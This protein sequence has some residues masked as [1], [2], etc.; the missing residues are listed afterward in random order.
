MKLRTILAGI[1]V[2]GSFPIAATAASREA[3]K[4]EPV[5]LACEYRENPLGIDVQK[6][7]LFWWLADRK[8]ETGSGHREISSY[9][10][11]IP[12]GVQQTA[13]Q[14]LVA[15]SE[16]L[17][18]KDQGDL[19]ESGR[20]ESNQSIQVEYSGKPLGSFQYCYWKVRVWTKTNSEPGTLNSVCGPWS[21]PAFWVT[22]L[23]KPDDWQ[24]K[25]I[26]FPANETS[27][28]MRKEFSIDAAPGRA[29][30]F[31]NVK[32]YYEL[33]VNGKKVDDDVLSPAVSDFSKRTFY[34]AH[35]ISRF[36][37]PGK[38]C[39]G[40]W[41]GTG[42]ARSGM[43]ARV[44][45]N[46]TIGGRDEV[47]GTDK[48]WT[49]SPSSYTLLGGWKWAD[50]GV[51]SLD[52][53]RDIP[54]WS[55]A[56]C[57]TGKWMPV[58]ECRAPAGVVVA[59]TCEPNRIGRTIPLVKCTALGKNIWELDFGVN[60]TGWLKI[61]MPK[62][63]QGTRISWL[64]A[65]RRYQSIEGD[66][67]PAGNIRATRAFRVKADGGDIAYQYFNQKDEFISAGKE[68]EQFCSKFSYHG[69]RY[70][71]LY[72]FPVQ[73]TQDD[74]EALPIA[75]DLGAAGSFECSNDLLNRI[76]Q[77]NLWTLRCL[78]LGGYMVDC[79]HRERLGYGDGQ[80]GFDSMVMSRN[81]PAFYAKWANDWLDG[82]NPSTGELPY[83]A[84]R[85][86]GGGGLPGAA[87]AA[88][89]PSN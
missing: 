45:L 16:E 32:G 62:L 28:W 37:R 7:R 83:T 87:Q 64:Y 78:S 71:I 58:E 56:G 82:Q 49:F 60:L 70:V 75:S 22:G 1:L 41:L 38:N 40:V 80:V 13:Y 44:Q 54:D 84:P 20:V 59:Q 50:Y 21:K 61:R 43:S 89:C 26:K 39:I 2:L 15:S 3:D 63:A 18:N 76:Y 53:N 81:A 31:V 36:L 52:A 72:D 47:I 67:T 57:K 65:D 17:L 66:K 86:G 79:P 24:A 42:W 11:E 12:R 4:F 48:T 35:D 9:G 6:P 69:F 14:I 33:Y 55:E 85:M 29:M 30:A 46:M 10:S 27:P 51:E 23:L 19:W 34:R 88:F 73:P 5:R 74:V 8:Q 77:V 68:G 25:W